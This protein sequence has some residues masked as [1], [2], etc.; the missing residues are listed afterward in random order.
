MPSKISVWEAAARLVSRNIHKCSYYH[1]RPLTLLTP[2]L[3]YGRHKDGEI[4]IW[5]L[6]EGR[7]RMSLNSHKGAISVLK[8]DKNSTL[9]A[10]GSQDTSIILWDIISE[11]S[12]YQ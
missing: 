5:N 7:V 3:D 8:F 6:E 2:S 9:L 10:S 11:Q 4:V 1:Q 12:L